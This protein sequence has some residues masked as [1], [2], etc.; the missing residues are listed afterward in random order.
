MART[1]RYASQH[2]GRAPPWSGR[3]VGVVIPMK[4]ALAIRQEIRRLNSQEPG[5]FTLRGFGRVVVWRHSHPIGSFTLLQNR[6]RSG[7]AT[8]RRVE[9]SE[10]EGY[11][12]SDV[13]RALEHL[14]G[15][16]LGPTGLGLADRPTA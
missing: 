16:R 3:D 14:A 9:W 6:P 1:P 8:V 10:R 12:E 2:A 7:L 11:A 15:Q 5:Q 4:L 13:W